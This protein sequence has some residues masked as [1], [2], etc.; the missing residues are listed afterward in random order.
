MSKH[1]RLTPITLVLL[2]VTAPSLAADPA[3]DM[4]GP[5][6]PAVAEALEAEAA[7]KAAQTTPRSVTVPVEE[8]LQ[9]LRDREDSETVWEEHSTVGITPEEVIKPVDE[10]FKEPA[11]SS[12]TEAA[13]AAGDVVASLIAKP[14]DDPLDELSAGPEPGPQDLLFQDARRFYSQGRAKDFRKILPQLA[15]HPLEGYAE[16]WDILLDVKKTPEDL[17]LGKR[18]DA[19]LARHKGEYI[20]ENAVMEY[21]K[22]AGEHVSKARYDALYNRLVWNRDEPELAAW[23]HYHDLEY[24]VEQKRGIA[25]ALLAA[26]TLY[27]D[28]GPVSRNAFQMLGDAIGRADPSW[29]WTRVI[30]LLQKGANRETKRALESVS[31]SDL[32]A[33]RA[34]LGRILDRPENWFRRQKNPK[35]LKAR[36]AVFAALRLSRTNP[37]MAAKLATAAVDPR[38]SSFW[39]SL[40][41]TRIG[42]T[43]VSRLD[44]KAWEY[45]R[46]ANENALKEQPL[47]V[48]NVEQLIAW[49][50]RA[51]M[52]EGEWAAVSRL[53][54]MLPSSVRSEETWIYWRGRALEARGLRKAAR[55]EYAKLADRISFY[56]KLSAERLGRPC[57][58]AKPPKEM[59]AR[60]EI[61]AWGKNPSIERAKAFYRLKMFSDGH[62]EWNWA[63][64]GITPQGRIALAAYAR[65]EH[66]IHRMINTSDR[67]GTDLV[68]IEQ[69]YPRPHLTLIERASEAQSLPSSWVYG[70]IRQESRFIPAVSSAVGA[71]GLMQIMPA[72][73]KWTAKKLGIK[74]YRHSSLTELEMNLV[75]GTAYLHMLAEDAE[76]S[77]IL[78]TAAYNAGPKRARIWREALNGKAMDAP[79][80]IETIPYFETREYVKNVLSNMHTYSWFGEKPIRSFT[81]FLGKVGPATGKAM[82]LP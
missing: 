44:P 64:R 70:L 58:F 45:F 38:A 1:P 43:A 37:E 59:P 21:L 19:F 72:T 51:A 56:G 77:Y 82:D 5:L 27:R 71:R 31:L 6:T 16:L 53:I 18:L 48:S 68:V 55:A 30:L 81:E 4:P 78:A 41:W 61:L 69:R 11:K 73:A 65:Q 76:G 3:Y 79:V 57:A 8:R 60:A 17:A 39:R 63:M 24:A 46:H 74:N 10:A 47:A 50:A 52:R 67:S 34:E 26:K 15:G 23:K 40:V 36:L 66:L 28:A 2:A 29:R 9:S 12:E 54:D 13:N 49:R 14:V 22:L 25:K 33:S 62:R 80:F 7:E 75:L 35:K 32:P 20:A 42:Y